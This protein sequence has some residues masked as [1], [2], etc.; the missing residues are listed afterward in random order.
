[1]LRKQHAAQRRFFY[2]YYR[3]KDRWS[4]HYRGK[5]YVVDDLTCLAPAEGWKNDRQPR[6]VMRGFARKVEID[7]GRAVIYE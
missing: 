4:V 2:H 7:G 5:C 3:Q 1:M 6:R